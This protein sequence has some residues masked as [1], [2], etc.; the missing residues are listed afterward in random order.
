MPLRS[1][2]FFTA[3]NASSAFLAEWKF[4]GMRSLRIMVHSAVLDSILTFGSANWMMGTF[5]KSD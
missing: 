5:E 3:Q 4:K 2:T 1:H